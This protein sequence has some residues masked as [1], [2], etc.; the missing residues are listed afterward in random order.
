LLLHLHHSGIHLCHL[1]HLHLKHVHLLRW[2]HE[3]RLG[4]TKV[5]VERI[6]HLAKLRHLRLHVLE[7]LSRVL[8]GIRV[9]V[10]IS[11]SGLTDLQETFVK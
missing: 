10:W 2:V 11:I 6:R 9:L 7:V 8:C 3:S 5:R 4:H 1:C